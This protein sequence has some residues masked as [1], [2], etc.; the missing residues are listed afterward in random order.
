MNKEK[1][2]VKIKK[3]YDNKGKSFDRYIVL[4]DNNEI[5][6]IGE[7]PKDFEEYLGT[8]GNPETGISSIKDIHDK[9]KKLSL[10]NIPPEIKD[11]LKRYNDLINDNP[12]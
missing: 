12:I 2:D 11:W 4:L 8:V 9:G 6:S 10:E 7:V 3:I 1:S 5:W